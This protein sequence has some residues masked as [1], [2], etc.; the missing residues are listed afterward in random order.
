MIDDFA[1]ASRD[2]QNL[3]R[4]LA[5]RYFVGIPQVHDERLVRIED[6]QP[7]DALN[8]V[9]HVAEAARLRTVSVQGQ[10]F[11]PER[12]THEIGQDPSVTEAHAR[13]V[14]VEDSGYPHAHAVGA[15]VGHRHRLPITLCL[16]VDAPHPHRIDVSPIALRLRVDQGVAIDFRSRSNQERGSLG[17]RQSQRIIGAEPPGLQR[18]DRVLQVVFG[19]GRTRKVQDVVDRPLNGDSFC[20]IVVNESKSR[21]GFEVG[22]VLSARCQEVIQTDDLAPFR[23][24]ALAEVRAHEA[25]T[26]GHHGSLGSF[27][28]SG[29]SGPVP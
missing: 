10:R 8:Q 27:H 24:Q 22:D 12:L 15:M 13:P 18:R 1:R 23:Q 25:R 16:I 14:G 6:E 19:A 3:L 9:A 26:P 29:D 17:L 5:H 28:L 21:D 7:V 20:Y 4:K 11:P 2:L